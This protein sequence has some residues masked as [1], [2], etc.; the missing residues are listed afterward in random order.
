MIPC[1]KLRKP[2]QIAVSGRRL[3]AALPNSGR[4]TQRLECHLHTVEVTGSNP[5]SP[6]RDFAGLAIRCNMLQKMSFSVVSRQLRQLFNIFCHL[7]RP[8]QGGHPELQ[9]LVT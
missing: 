7:Q 4:L 9:K 1:R 3:E 8:V 2:I 5:V 6:I